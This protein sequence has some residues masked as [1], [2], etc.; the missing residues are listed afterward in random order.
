MW[1]EEVVSLGWSGTDSFGW[2][3]PGGRRV[4]MGDRSQALCHPNRLRAPELN[5]RG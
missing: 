3:G 4:S 2:S 5:K 1:E